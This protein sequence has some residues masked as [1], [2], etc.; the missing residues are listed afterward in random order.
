MP[1]EGSGEHRSARQAAP[2][3]QD[4]LE[5]QVV[6]KAVVCQAVDQRTAK[7][8]ITDGAFQLVG[9]R[10]WARRRQMRNSSEPIGMRRYCVGKR[11]IDVVRECDAVV[12]FDQIGT[13]TGERKNPHGDTGFIHVG[14][15]LYADVGQLLFQDRAEAR[16]KSP[17]RD[18]LRVDPANKG[19]NGE[20]LLKRGKT[21]ERFLQLSFAWAET[22]PVGR[23][24]ECVSRGIQ[25]RLP[26]PLGH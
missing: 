2:P 6:Q 19:W 20:M 17:V 14:D 10:W 7:A 25:R 4:R 23:L 11:V 3:M 26:K 12:S 16:R 1:A 13:R 8:V 21:Q 24:L 18:H 5:A 9:R 15:P 22:A